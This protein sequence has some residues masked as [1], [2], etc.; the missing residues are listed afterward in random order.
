[1]VSH[2]EDD[3]TYEYYMLPPTD[4]LMKMLQNK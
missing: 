4:L 1:M 2:I 3:A